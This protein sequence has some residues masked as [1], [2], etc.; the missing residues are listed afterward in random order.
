MHNLCKLD[1]RNPSGNPD[2]QFEH[3]APEKN[4]PYDRVYR[5]LAY[6]R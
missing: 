2:F 1:S 4:T 3:Y 5:Y 6:N